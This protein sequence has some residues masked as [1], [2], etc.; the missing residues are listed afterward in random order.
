MPLRYQEFQSMSHRMLS[1]NSHGAPCHVEFMDREMVAML[2][3][4]STTEK[5]AMVGAVHRTMRLLM[6]SGI[7][8]KNPEWS[9]EQVRAEI[10]R[11]IFHGAT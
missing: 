4:K 3:S 6:A 5:I 9:D 7:R 10:N 2:Q 1:P 11:R 8:G